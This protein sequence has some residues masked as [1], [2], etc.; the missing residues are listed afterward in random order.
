MKRLLVVLAALWSCRE[1]PELPV[2][3]P[4]PEAPQ[5][6]SCDAGDEAWV[7]RVLP[8]V[9]GRRAVGA[10]EVQVWA[11]MANQHGRPAALAGM[12]ESPEYAAWWTTWLTDAL[13]VAR[14]GD[15]EFEDCF[16]DTWQPVHDG[17]LTQH[18]RGSTT[19]WNDPFEGGPFTMRDVLRDA[20]V[21][22]DLAVAWQA[23][24]Y[25]RM[26]RPVD[27]ANVSLEELEYNRRVNFAEGFY[28]TYL[29]RNL[30]CIACHNS[31]FSVTDAVDA[32]VDRTWQLPGLH[33]TALLGSNTAFDRDALF[34]MFR[35][36]AVTWGSR[37]P[38][39]MA[40]VCGELTGPAAVDD[41]DLLGQDASFFIEGFDATGSVWDLER[42]L[43]A[44]A[45]ALRRD[46]LAIAPD[47]TVDGRES[48]AYLVGARIVDRV[49][50]AATGGRLTISHGFPRN[51]ES[52]ARLE[53]YTD[54]FVSEGFSLRTLLTDVTTDELFNPDL[55]DA[56][57]AQHYGLDPVV[58]PWSVEDDDPAK[59]RNSPGDLVQRLPARVLYRS[60]Q[61]HLGRNPPVEW[62]PSENEEDFQASLG[63]FL[64]E[65]QPGFNGTDLQ[66][67]LAF[68]TRFGTCGDVTD[69]DWLASL[70]AQVGDASTEEVVLHLKD[71]LLADARLTPEERPLLEALVGPLERR[72]DLVPPRAMR[73]VCGAFM[74]SAP[75]VLRVVPQTSNPPARGLQRADWC[76]S[77]RNLMARAGFDVATCD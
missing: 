58:L 75:Y 37:R 70:L 24:L 36:D 46:G 22:D 8:L 42:Q 13:A 21:A 47:G 6:A 9:W 48:F 16:G 65:S 18:L 72:A 57:D 59:R 66:G 10:A 7:Q 55:P 30:D 32:R 40:E 31:Q 63:V 12:M 64:R 50:E 74:N 77:V 4:P 2:A 38:W 54:H 69:D 61:L 43:A 26:A 73:L 25:A 28:E 5:R 1:A 53:R 29:N 35:H 33:E 39:G 41:V 11:S 27:G 15:K 19:P 68:Q 60:A 52:A 34:A 14:I 49:F 76:P 44:G 23:N 20:V 3:T 71:H 17:R 51:L 62:N 45:R 56:C 67:M